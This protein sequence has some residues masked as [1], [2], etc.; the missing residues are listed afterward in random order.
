MFKNQ[1]S[2]LLIASA[3]LML[4][5][6]AAAEPGKGKSGAGVT[7]TAASKG[8]AVTAESLMKRYENLAGSPTNAE[9]LVKGLRYQLE[10]VLV[11]ASSTPAA[12]PT[13]GLSP[14]GPMG[15]V[16]PTCPVPPPPSDTVKFVPPTDPMGLGNIDIALALTEAQLDKK[17][18]ALPP[19]PAQLKDA[20]MTVLDLRAGGSGWGD[21]A[22]TLDFELK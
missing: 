13:G 19:K 6:A 7:A 2:I 21:V 14:M 10:I 5:G 8:G 1:A 15:P 17:D 22:K 3:L 9:S 20:L 18:V 4:P 11:G 12:G 16:C